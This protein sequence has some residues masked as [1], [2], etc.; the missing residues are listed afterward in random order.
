MML[1][2]FRMT[3]DTEGHNNCGSKPVHDFMVSWTP[4]FVDSPIISRRECQPKSHCL[5]LGTVMYP[6]KLAD[7]L[8]QR[9]NSQ[10]K[11]TCS[12]YLARP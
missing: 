8:C 2:S 4:F 3:S 11:N 1:N 7:V 6:V 9:S 5:P 10:N 12:I